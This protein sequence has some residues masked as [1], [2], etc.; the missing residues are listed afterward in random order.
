[1][2]KTKSKF[3]ILILILIT[4]LVLFFS[5]K[6][7]FNTI[8]NQIFSINPI[9][10]LLAIVF[11][12]IYWL[13][14]SIV[15]KLFINKVKPEY[16]LKK[17]FKLQLMTQFFNAV[18]P[19]SSGGQPF[20]AYYMKKDGIRIAD[21]TNILIQ[22]F[23]SYQIALVLLGIISILS[24]HIF[25][26]F[27]EVGLLKKLVTIGLSI[28]ILVVI[29]L[30]FISFNKKGNKFLLKLFVNILSKLKIVKNKNDKLSKWNEYVNDFHSG[31]KTLFDDKLLFIKSIFLNLLGL[32]VLYLVPLIILF[33][34]NDFIT[35]N[36]ALAI[37]SSAYVMLI[38]AFVPIP[39]GT[40]GLEYSFIA[41]YGVFIKGSILN[42]VMLLWRFVTYYFGMIVGAI[43]VNI[44]E[45]K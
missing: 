2:S 23:I 8:V 3:N 41:F 21:S 34:F 16:T 30:F 6:D 37:V 22:N 26:I 10:L 13:F 4:I 1:M 32:C 45:R 14:G 35:I 15:M 44:K 33:G 43:A 19:F 29:V 40:G 25:N 24:N 20:Q 31:A 27:P 28:N 7:N 39:G 17:A 11:V 5:L 38:G 36:G 18:T 42:A 12:I 9:F